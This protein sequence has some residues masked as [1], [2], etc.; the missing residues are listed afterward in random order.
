ALGE[1]MEARPLFEDKFVVVAGAR[2]KVGRRKLA[3][4]DLVD[5]RWVLPP[6][7]SLPG[8]MIADVF[9]AE[10]L[11]PPQA[12]IVSFSV[13]LH[14][15]LLASGRFVTMLPLSMLH[16]GKHL[17]L[18]PLPVATIKKAYSIGIVAL[19]NR[20]LAPFARVFI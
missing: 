13:P 7:D 19:R 15:H 10:G 20:T 3:L 12:H 2:T 1:D 17:S 14:Q 18:K 6:P 4:A 8:S 9:R 5:E 11:E 16:F